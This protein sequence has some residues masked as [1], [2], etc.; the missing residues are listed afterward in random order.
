MPNIGYYEKCV[1][2]CSFEA[3]SINQ[4]S[5]VDTITSCNATLNTP[6]ISSGQQVLASLS[7][8]SVYL[9]RDCALLIVLS[10]LWHTI[11]YAGLV[12]RVYRAR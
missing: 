7:F 2:V 9:W 12:I 4:W 1:H 3:V 11:G 8:D 6:C 10:V 5:G